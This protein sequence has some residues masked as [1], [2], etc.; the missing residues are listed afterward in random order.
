MGGVR[1]N[2]SKWQR[3]MYATLASP[4]V[5]CNDLS[6]LVMHRHKQRAYNFPDQFRGIAPIT[7]LRISHGAV[8]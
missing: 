1:E 8:L 6:S 7:A 3:R 2:C 5:Y 4:P